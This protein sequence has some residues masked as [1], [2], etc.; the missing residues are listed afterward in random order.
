[1][2]ADARVDVR[3]RA[4]AD[5]ARVGERLGRARPSINSRF[6]HVHRTMCVSDCMYVIRVH[7]RRTN[8]EKNQTSR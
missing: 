1:M 3:A 2:F 5:A 6:G 4:C 8:W 7:W